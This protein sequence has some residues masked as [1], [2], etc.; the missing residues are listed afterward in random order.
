MCWEREAR[1]IEAAWREAAA[2]AL[3]SETPV[4]LA[5]AARVFLRLGDVLANWGRES[6]EVEVVLRDAALLGSESATTEGAEVV[7]KVSG[8]FQ[9]SSNAGTS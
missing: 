8:R 3:E 5:A 6:Q 2:A 4:G 9:G 7:D 1:E